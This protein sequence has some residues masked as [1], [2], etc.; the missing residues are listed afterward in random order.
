MTRTCH[1]LR[2]P[3]IA[4]MLAVAT[5]C[6]G[7]PG[8][9]GTPTPQVRTEVGGGF[10]AQYIGKF[11]WTPCSKNDAGRFSFRG[12][13]RA[14]YL[15]ESTESGDLSGK[16]T[17]RTCTWSGTATLASLRHPANSVTFSVR[18]KD[19]DGFGPCRNG[20]NFVVKRGAGKLLHASGS[21]AV[22]LACTGTFHGSNIDS[23][24]G[25]LTL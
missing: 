5:A 9:A 25:S 6:A 24:N 12:S 3:V 2:L 4:V 23:W 1:R 21:G 13:G 17:G 18:L 19:R 14:E 15:H 11:K 8:S 10:V 7:S 20:I 22:L 16:L